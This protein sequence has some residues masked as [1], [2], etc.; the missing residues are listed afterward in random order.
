MDQ[1]KTPAI[2]RQENPIACT[3]E[4]GEMAERG[5]EMEALARAALLRRTR[6]GNSLQLIF[7]RTPQ[8]EAGIAS[9]VQRERQC[10]SFL[11]FEV[12]SGGDEVVLDI[13]GPADAQPVL[14]AIYAAGLANK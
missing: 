6:T 5:R 7:R 13:S 10:C 12:K 11:T 9:L 4:A 2:E 8:V 1:T 3:L 14:D